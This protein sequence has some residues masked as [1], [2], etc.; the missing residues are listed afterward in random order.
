MAS[1]SKKVLVLNRNWCAVGVVGLPRA[2]SL[3]FTHYEDGEPRARV[4]TPPPKGSYEVWDWRDWSQMRPEAGEEG[5]VSASRVYK[6]P[7]VMLLTRY[8]GMPI[9]KVNFCRRAIWKRDNHTCQYCGIR[10]AQDECTLDHIV[11]R[12]LGGETSWA[13]C[14]LACYQCNSQKAD[15]RPEHATRPKDKAKAR[16][17]KGHSPM[18]LLKEP[19]RPEYSLIRDRVKIL[20]TWKH[21]VDRLYWEMPLDNDMSD[22]SDFE[23]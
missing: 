19:V 5:L 7:E 4:I 6:I 21:W 20:D 22:D 16:K 12:S 1:V 10:P 17:W 11:P 9:Q 23:L 13:N 18:R 15:R 2:V 14:V 8:E 3:L